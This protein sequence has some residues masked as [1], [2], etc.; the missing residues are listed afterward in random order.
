MR[1][2]A[3]DPERWLGQT[4]EAGTLYVNVTVE[5]RVGSF[6]V[7]QARGLAAAIEQAADEV[8]E[9]RGIST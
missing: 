6:T 3:E 5:D 8:E 7:E 1:R 2:D 9:S 4:V